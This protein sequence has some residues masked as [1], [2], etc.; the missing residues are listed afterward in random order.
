MGRVK[1]ALLP[2]NVAD[3]H[4]GYDQD[5]LEQIN[6]PLINEDLIRLNEQC[7]LAELEL[8]A[9]DLTEKE[10]RCSF[11]QDTFSLEDLRDLQLRIKKIIRD[12]GDGEV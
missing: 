2:E 1:E 10:Y 8:I 3:H 11:Y 9:N 5:I 12:F 4:E 6:P 7:L